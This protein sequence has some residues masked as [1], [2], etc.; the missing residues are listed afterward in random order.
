LNI[1]NIINIAAWIACAAI[2]GLLTFDVARV[3]MKNK[4]GQDGEWYE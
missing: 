2:L 3:E 1:W 4:E